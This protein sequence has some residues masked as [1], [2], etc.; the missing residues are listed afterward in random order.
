MT[1]STGSGNIANPGSIAVILGPIPHFP[2]IPFSC[3]TVLEFLYN[4]WGLGTE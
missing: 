1:L 4:L 2:L 3:Y